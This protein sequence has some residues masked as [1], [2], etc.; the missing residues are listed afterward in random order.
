MDK[1][2]SSWPKIVEYAGL[3]EYEA[4]IYLALIDLGFAGA[5]KLSM[6]CEVPRTKVYNTLKKLI[7][8]GLVVDVPGK[9][10]KF[11]AVDPDI[12]LKR[13]LLLIKKR[14]QEFESMVSSLAETYQRKQL[15][16]ERQKI[17]IGEELRKTIWLYNV[18]VIME[19]AADMF[20]YE[21]RN[22]RIL[23]LMQTRLN[24]ISPDI[25]DEDIILIIDF[26]NNYIDRLWFNM[27]VDF[28]YEAGEQG[29][30]IFDELIQK[31]GIRIKSLIKAMH[32]KDPQIKKL[33]IYSEL[34]KFTN[35][36]REKLYELE[37]RTKGLDI[38]QPTKIK[39]LDSIPPKKLELYKILEKYGAVN[40]S[41]HALASGTKSNYFFDIDRLLSDPESVQI[42]SD[43]YA[44]MIN[45]MQSK[46]KVIHKLAF[47]EKSVGTIGVLPLMSFII[48]KV[49]IPGLVVRFRKDFQ[50]GQIKSGY[51]QELK[52]KERVAIISDVLTGGTGIIKAMNIISGYKAITAYAGVIY[53]RGQGAKEKIEKKYGIEVKSIIDS[54]ELLRVFGIPKD[55][56]FD[57]N[58]DT[59]LEADIIPLARWKVERIRDEL[60]YEMIERLKN[61]KIKLKKK[62]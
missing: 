58:P 24:E 13:N 61:S 28:S 32:E 4:K 21:P 44:D 57:F 45:E 47:I 50:I 46:G 3:S 19:D 9:P 11:A 14:A 62:V 52:E 25:Q 51:G 30:D 40:Q 22:S 7:D 18:T 33:K 10:K 16:V 20:Y 2:V 60:G 27:A 26:L 6:S 5:R 43:H 8:L 56:E 41:E 36:Y 55:E 39:N 29:K 1:T 34:L 12:S 17:D 37:I 35:L 23:R 49:K 59:N 42:V 48:S 53:D 54:E 38:S 15:E 31:I